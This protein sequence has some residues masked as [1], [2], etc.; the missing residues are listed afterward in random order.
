VN[1][2]LVVN[3]SADARL[4]ADTVHDVDVRATDSIDID[5]L[6]WHGGPHVLVMRSG[7]RL[8]APEL[9]HMSNLRHIVRA[10][11]GLDA[12]DTSAVHA[13]G[14]SIHRNPL[15]SADA[16]A[17][18]A[19]TATL[20]LA[21]RI[22]LGH[23]ALS[24]GRYVKHDCVAPPLA[25]CDV[26]VWGAGPVGR[27]C[28][29]VLKPMVRH[30]AYAARTTVPSFLPQ[31]PADELP[32]W[33]DVHVIALPL[34]S[35]TRHRIGPVFLDAAAARR[36]LLV[37]VGRLD[38]LDLTACLNALA[39]GRLGG[40]AVDPVDPEHLPWPTPAEPLNLLATPHLGAQRGDV[41]R[42]LDLWTADTVAGLFPK[43]HP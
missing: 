39:D 34:T 35:A 8:G 32:T 19:L 42:K 33:A 22:P 25:E 30:V 12:I 11:S 9:A 20:A 38:T 4:L 26:A 17:E 27:A 40:L 16:V 21:R 24:A 7:T 1:T 13:A 18:W 37:C 3:G 23:N 29:A 10:G 2:L 6:P 31:R 41:R 28:G 15:P 36:P 14:V 5:H 43:A